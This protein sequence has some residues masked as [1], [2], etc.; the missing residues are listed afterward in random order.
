MRGEIQRVF[1]ILLVVT[2]GAFAACSPGPLEVASLSPE[3]LRLD[4][5]AHWTFDEGTGTV[6]TDH[7]GN[8]HDGELTGG[9]W[10]TGRF[11]NALHFE[12]G[13]AV[14]VAN[15]PQASASWSV[16]LWARPPA[17]DFGDA[18]LTLI[19]TEIV[20]SGGWEMNARLTPASTIYDFAFPRGS[21]PND[22]TY[23]YFN[24]SCVE[25]N[26]WTHLVAVVDNQAQEIDFY[27][28]G[29]LQGRS[30]ITSSLLPGSSTLYVGRW[31]GADRL[32]TGD[33]D[34]I[35]IYNRALAPAEVVALDQHPV[36][37][38]P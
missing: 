36:A 25:A 31:P 6:I 7:S 34:D 35:A 9:T 37:D 14:A 12:L 27:S 24:C 30:P 1:R 15:F 2:A 13:D 5:V 21:Y 18:Y 33:L 29:N 26:Q 20:W 22:T 23:E 19:S 17:G 11:G 4:L 16:S 28:D 10:I 32:Y 8:G 38:P 3:S